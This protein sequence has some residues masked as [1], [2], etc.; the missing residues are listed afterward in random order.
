MVTKTSRLVPARIGRFGVARVLDS[1]AYGTAYF[2]RDARLGR[3]V[4]VKT[5]PTLG[6]AGETRGHIDRLLAGARTVGEL[7]H[8][9][10]VPLID[11]GE[12]NGVPFLVYEQVEGEALSA[13]L[14]AEPMEIDRALEITI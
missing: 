7:S 13:T 8:P 2:A 6:V 3:P 12:D 9:G 14:R 4:I 5:L 10:I 1:G 11:A